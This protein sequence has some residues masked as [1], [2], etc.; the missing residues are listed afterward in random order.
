MIKKA[1]IYDLKIV[2][3]RIYRAGGFLGAMTFI[4][5]EWIK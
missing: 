3:Y 4:G 2:D 5:Y 1:I